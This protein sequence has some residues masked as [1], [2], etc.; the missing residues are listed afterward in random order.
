MAS[1]DAIVAFLDAELDAAG[2]A[3]MLPVG[4]QV[5]GAEAVTKV[6]TGVSASLELFRRTAAAGGQLLIVHHGLFWDS[7]SRRIGPA[8][9][10]RLRILFD[11]GISLV[12]YHLCLDAHPSLGNN[13]ILCGRLGLTELEPFAEHRGRTIGFVGHVRPAIPADELLA[14]VRREV[15]PAPLA[16]LEGPPEVGRVAVVSGG[17]ADDFLRAVA[18]GADAF[19]TGEASE[20]TLHRAREARAH[21]IAAGHYA[22]EVF[23]VRALGE[24]VAERFGVAHEFV[25]LP[26]PV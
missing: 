24:L 20:P 22:T 3:D 18:A 14:R 5:T 13:A 25:D 19:V 15:A 6:V 23:G 4:L 26:N 9:R 1:R 12:A 17:A 11:A 21:F 8:E 2:F 16:F 10:E 7:D